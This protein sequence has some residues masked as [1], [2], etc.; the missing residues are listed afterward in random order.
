M[1][2][3]DKSVVFASAYRFTVLFSY[4]SSDPSYTLAPTVGWTAIEMSAGIV[5]ACLPTMG[6]IFGAVG[7]SLGVKRTLLTTRGGGG[8]GGT[9]DSYSSSS[10]ERGGGGHPESTTGGRS[11]DHRTTES[12]EVI[13]TNN[14]AGFFYRLSD[15]D[16]DNG[17]G[18]TATDHHRVPL[19]VDAGLRPDHRHAYH[20]TSKPGKGGGE[21]DSLSGD[22]IP[23][24]GIR[25]RTDFRHSSSPGEI[26]DC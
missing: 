16:D 25:V 15:G 20:V 8:G 26:N 23:L 11:A 5:S 3:T 13:R 19:P 24:Q 12:A 17:S 10:K 21:G 22:E 7:R 1:L 4:S 14:G 9:K 6:P 2:T 18:I